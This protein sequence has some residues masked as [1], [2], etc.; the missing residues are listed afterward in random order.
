[1]LLGNINKLYQLMHDTYKITQTIPLM[2]SSITMHTELKDIQLDENGLTIWEN[3]RITGSTSP[4]QKNTFNESLSNRQALLNHYWFQ[5]LAQGAFDAKKFITRFT[6]KEFHDKF[7]F[8]FVVG[9]LGD[10]LNGVTKDYGYLSEVK[11]ECDVK[12]K[13]SIDIEVI[14]SNVSYSDFNLV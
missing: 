11:V 6:Q 8:D 2:N 12:H 9:D 13:D 1:M 10:V 5:E 4:F 3:S 7:L 14:Y